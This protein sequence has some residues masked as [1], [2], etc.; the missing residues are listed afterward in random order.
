MRLLDSV[1]MVI[2]LLIVII[3]LLIGIVFS[4]QL[5]DFAMAQK[6]KV[7]IETSRNLSETPQL[8]DMIVDKNKHLFL[9][10]LVVKFKQNTES[11]AVIIT[12]HA[13]KIITHSNSRSTGIKLNN[14]YINK[15]LKGGNSYIYRY[16]NQDAKLISGTAPI[17]DSLKNIVGLVSVVYTV[18]Y[19]RFISQSYLQ[20]T[21]FYIFLFFI[22]AMGA[23]VIIAQGVKN[24]I[25]GLEP[26][27]IA[28]LFQ[29][30]TAIIE[31]IR[32]GVL[33]SDRNGIIIL[34]NSKA[35]ELLDLK[36]QPVE[37]I[38]IETFFPKPAIQ[39]ALKGS[40]PVYDAE[41]V[42]R[43]IAIQCNIIPFTT[44]QEAGG[45]VATFRKKDEIDLITGE[46]SQIT[47]YSELLRAQTHEYSNRLHTIAG[48]LQTKE[49]Q[50]VLDLIAEETDDQKRIVR[51][52]MEIVGDNALRSL[53]LGKYMH[54]RELKIDFE[55][56][57]E[58]SMNN[59]PQNISRYQLITILGN[60]LD[61]AFEA[62]I[63]SD[64]P[65]KVFLS[66]SDFGDLIF[67]IED[68][69]PG[70][71]EE[72]IE[73]LFERGTTSKQREGHGIGLYLVHHALLTMDGSISTLKS[74][75]GGARFTVTIQILDKES[76]D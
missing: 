15:A 6:E 37:G 8:G 13:G 59:I 53:L 44:V 46:L 64:R 55:I 67:E 66:M 32:S 14:P 63:H 41:V 48:L 60:L 9:K 34:K 71:P 51:L 5:F 31:S 72:V 47:R 12:D 69:G 3:L 20:K 52:L 24:A 42:I 58:S 1:V 22:F 19:I 26:S 21:I 57:R 74:D 33:A 73:S 56:D 39:R 43:G 30:R 62:T 16:K 11:A 70:I 17:R 45:V 54:A 75:L 29:T 25:F 4:G 28:N 18:E 2:V 61:N 76:R 27:E 65:K 49:Y 38:P 10:R 23:S 36:G 35:E 68:S 50:E 7:A 40:I